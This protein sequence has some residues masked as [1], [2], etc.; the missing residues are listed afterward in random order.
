MITLLVHT[1]DTKDPGHNIG[2]SS[3]VLGN[4]EGEVSRILEQMEECGIP[5]L[6]HTV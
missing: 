1:A 4:E 5:I 6:L 3:I 2:S